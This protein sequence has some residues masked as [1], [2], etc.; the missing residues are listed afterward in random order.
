MFV[1]TGITGQ[2]GGVIA[3]LLLS[4]N[5]EV[6][7]VVRSVKK[8]QYWASQGCDVAIAEM[9][10]AVALSKAFTNVEGVFILLPPNFDPSAGFPESREIITALRIAL[11]ETR[12]QKV[13]CL[14]TIGA[15]ATQPN[16]LTQLG[17]MEDVLG[18]LPLPTAFIRAAWFIENAAW[19]IPS[20]QEQGEIPSFLQPLDRAIP[21]V[22]TADVGCTAAALLQET[23]SGKRIIELRGPESISPNQLAASFTRLLGRKVKAYAVPRYDWNALF[24]AQGMQN[25]LPRIQMLDGFNAG[26]IT[27]SGSQ[28]EQRVG[29]LGLETV[30]STLI[31]KHFSEQPEIL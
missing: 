12:P 24:L 14:S 2:V 5:H 23:W 1:I 16:L 31:K 19:D 8:G 3:R 15:Q 26:W 17:I 20:A 22:A 30:L 6:R 4:K 13:V 29:I 11:E 9:N 25:P 18:T 28:T 27:F 10:D 7:A 21:M